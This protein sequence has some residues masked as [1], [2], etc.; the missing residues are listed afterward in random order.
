MFCGVD[1]RVKPES[2]NDENFDNNFN[3]I[4]SSLDEYDDEYSDMKKKRRI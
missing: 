2:E 1:K 4:T 3:E